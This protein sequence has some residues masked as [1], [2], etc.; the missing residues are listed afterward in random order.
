MLRR[1]ST[2]LRA[3][4]DNERTESLAAALEHALQFFDGVPEQILCDNSKTIVIEGNAYGE[5]KHRYNP[6]DAIKQIWDGYETLTLPIPEAANFYHRV[7]ERR[8][9]L[10]SL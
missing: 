4:T 2:P 9:S 3:F 7:D 8:W 10:H 6:F 5:G 1:G